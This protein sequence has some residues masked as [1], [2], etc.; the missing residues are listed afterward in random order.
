MKNGNPNVK[1]VDTMLFKALNF[2]NKGKIT[3][4]LFSIPIKDHRKARKFLAFLGHLLIIRT[5]SSGYISN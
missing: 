4:A 1:S 2:L 5:I 3:G